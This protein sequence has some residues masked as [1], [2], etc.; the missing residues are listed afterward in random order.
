MGG[1]RELHWDEANEEHIARHH[2]TADEVEEV[3][4]GKHWMLRASGRKRKAVFG[5]TAGGRYLLVILEMWDYGEY[6]VITARGMDQAERR[7]Y[8]AWRGRR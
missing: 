8:Q 2:V 3:C 5:Q 1:I 6:D 4:F 7:R